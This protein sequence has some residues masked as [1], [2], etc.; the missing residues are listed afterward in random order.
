M[1][2]HSKCRNLARRSIAIAATAATACGLAVVTAS[3]SEAAPVASGA[4]LSGRVLSAGRAVSRADVTL[5]AWPNAHTLGT[6]ANG[7][8]VPLAT[9]STAVTDANGRYSLSPDVAGLGAAYR[10]PDG[11]VNVEVDAS[12]T[13]AAQTYNVSIAAPSSVA[14]TNDMIA[15]ASSRPEQV[16]FDLSDQTVTTAMNGAPAMTKQVAAARHAAVPSAKISMGSA[17]GMQPDGGGVNCTSWASTYYPARQEVVTAIYT[18]ST[19]RAY[20]TETS[21]SSH[22]LGIGYAVDSGGWGQSGTANYTTNSSTAVTVG[23]SRATQVSN[24][25]NTRRFETLCK[26]IADGVPGQ[27]EYHSVRASG[28][29]YS[30]LT[31]SLNKYLYN[32]TWSPCIL[33]GADVTIEKQHGSDYEYSTGFKAP[34]VSLSA[35]AVYSSNTHIT[36]HTTDR[37]W[38]CPSNSN[39]GMDLSPMIGAKHY[40]P[41]CTQKPCPIIKTD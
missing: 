27:R 30:F 33:Y 34:Y 23:Y 19:A 15:V 37:E 14:S 11:T 17:A 7:A 3:P 40:V 1:N 18:D 5:V 31:P 8:R 12:S 13:T 22:T 41:P 39:L 16:S 9:I 20:M 4:V 25:V 32:M 21:S 29:F 10:E 28:G 2:R 26:W 6:L 38:F 36:F 24:Q 35:Q